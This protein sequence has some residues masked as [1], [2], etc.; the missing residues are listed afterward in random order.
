MLHYR[1]LQLCL[2]L[3]MRLEKIQRAL[4]FEQSPWMEPYIWMNTEL[5]KKA[6]GDFEKNLYQLMNNSVFGKT[7]ENLRKRVTVKLVRASEED[8]QRRLSA[9]PAFARANIMYTTTISR[10]FKSRLTLNRPVWG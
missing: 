8:K 3:G 1:N 9:S 7:M 4:R 2:S 6:S 5:R 10:R